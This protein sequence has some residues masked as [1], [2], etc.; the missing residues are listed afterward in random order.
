MWAREMG[1]SGII[2]LNCIVQFCIV[3]VLYCITGVL[4]SMEIGLTLKCPIEEVP[5]HC[6]HPVLIL[7]LLLHLYPILIFSGKFKYLNHKNSEFLAGNLNANMLF[8][9]TIK[10][11]LGPVLNLNPSF[12]RTC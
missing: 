10:H 2:Q 6:C 11:S 8:I 7:Q 12:Q 3:L 4:I 9:S 1:V 5:L